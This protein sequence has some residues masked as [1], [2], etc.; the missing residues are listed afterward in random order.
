MNFTF[1]SEIDGIACQ[2]EVEDY[3]RVKG[4]YSYHAAS[5]VDYYGYSDCVWKVLDENGKHAAWLEER[6][7]DDDEERISREIEEYVDW[8]ANDVE[9]VYN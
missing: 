8:L 5:D 1:D 9:Y 6:M 2:I 4:S 3:V 7:G